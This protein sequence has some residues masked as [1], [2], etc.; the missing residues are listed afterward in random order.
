MK[1]GQFTRLAAFDS[2]TAMVAA[3]ARSLRG[4]GF[5]LVGTFPAWTESLLSPLA[6]IVNHIPSSLRESLFV[7]AGQT[8]SMRANQ[9]H[10]AAVEEMCRW[11]T[12]QY[13]NRQYPAVAIGSTNG[14]AIHLF[15]ALG[16][17]WLPQTFLLPVARTGIAPDDAEQ[18]LAWGNLIAAEFLN[19][20]TDVSLH[21]MQD[22]IQDRLMVRAI[23]YFR[24]KKL[25]L[26]ASY[27]KFLKSSLAPDG[28]ILLIECGKIWPVVRLSERHYFQ[29]GATG[30]ASSE[31]YYRGGDR[32]R[33][34]LAK[35]HTSPSA[36]SPPKPDST[37]PEA[38]W[39]FHPELRRDI[40][41]FSAQNGRALKRITFQ[42]PEDLS[43]VT[44][45]FYRDWHR[46]EKPTTTRLLVE[47]FILLDPQWV[48]Q[49]RAIPYWTVFSV[50]PSLERALEYVATADSG[51]VFD[52]ILIMLFPHGVESVGLASV[53]DWEALSQYARSSCRFIGADRKAYPR[54]FAAF[55]R[56][57]RELWQRCEKAQS[58]HSV[59][60]SAVLK[61]IQDCGDPK[62]KIHS[63]EAGHLA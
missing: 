9:L 42:E 31:E 15:A 3:L 63:P 33:T 45:N 10:L 57:H 59:P 23:S 61:F 55:L 7:A 52:E 17:P 46:K 18:E 2:A 36:W 28:R 51:S 21:H 62:V 53:K 29:F 50:K 25:T 19:R 54:D 47:S 1:V 49:A 60:L 26:G 5:P 43:P 12:E 11:V 22:P 41:R 6:S 4:K 34:F 38:E 30:G 27:E 56:Y 14:A 8:E 24:I 39:G 32:I 35:Q 16:I 37:A 44:A 40:Q 13:P 58:P 20:N 48:L